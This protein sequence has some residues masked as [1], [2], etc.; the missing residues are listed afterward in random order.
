MKCT[1]L[2]TFHTNIF[3]NLKDL[4]KTEHP[5]LAALKKKH[6]PYNVA[7]QNIFR[8]LIFVH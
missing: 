1:T 3:I 2:G 6:H 8:R 7:T 4:T 5:R